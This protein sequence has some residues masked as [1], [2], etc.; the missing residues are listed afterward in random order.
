MTAAKLSVVLSVGAVMA[1]VFGGWDGAM[2]TLCVFI[3]MDYLSG[4][5]LAAVFRRSKHTDSGALDSRAGLKGICRKAGMMAVVI[6]AVR[7]DDLCG[8]EGMLR[9]GTIYALAAN[10]ALSIIENLGLMGVPLPKVLYAAVDRLRGKTEDKMKSASDGIQADSSE[11][12]SAQPAH[13]SPEPHEHT[14]TDI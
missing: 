1:A 2:I 11:E 5:V 10:E 6:L 3:L 4:I 8:L 14:D 12:Q 9:S 7:L 13:G